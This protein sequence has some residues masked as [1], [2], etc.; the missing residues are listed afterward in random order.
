[1]IEKM[2]KIFATH[3]KGTYNSTKTLANDPLENEVKKR[4]DQGVH[5]K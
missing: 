2:G 1:M 4:Q 5:R 3:I